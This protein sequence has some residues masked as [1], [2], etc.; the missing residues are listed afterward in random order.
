MKV[1]CN[2]D[3]IGPYKRAPNPV[4]CCIKVIERNI[5]IAAREC[6]SEDGIPVFPEGIAPADDVFPKSRLT[7]VE[8]GGCPTS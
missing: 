8:T 5:S 2:L 6:F 7:F 3:V 4:D 1:V